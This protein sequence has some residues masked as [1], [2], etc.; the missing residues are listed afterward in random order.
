MPLMCVQRQETSAIKAH[1][2]EQT[3]RQKKLISCLQRQHQDQAEVMDRQVQ[4]AE[5]LVR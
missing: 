2:A 3:S 1:F 5:S 4:A